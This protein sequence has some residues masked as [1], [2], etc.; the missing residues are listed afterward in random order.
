MVHGVLSLLIRNGV[1]YGY[2]EVNGGHSF[3]FI[4]RYLSG[5]LWPGFTPAK[6]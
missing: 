2:I 5:W 3:L 6:E 4:L 1:K